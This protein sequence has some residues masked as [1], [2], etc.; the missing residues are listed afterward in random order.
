MWPVSLGV[1]QHCLD[2]VLTLVSRSHLSTPRPIK[3]PVFGFDWATA[4]LP[5]ATV[6]TG[7]CT[8]R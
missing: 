3:T 8:Q 7:G 1:P 6:A 2:I 4:T 5:V